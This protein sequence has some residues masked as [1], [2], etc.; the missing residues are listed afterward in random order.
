[1]Q[2]ILSSFV[3]SSLFMSVQV[4]PFLHIMV[5]FVRNEDECRL[6]LKRGQPDTERLQLKSYRTRN[7]NAT[8]A[9]FE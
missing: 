4:V 9:R 1:M 5:L 8:P 2:T 7:R 3:C 6:A